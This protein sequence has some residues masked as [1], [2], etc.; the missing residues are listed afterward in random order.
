MLE[1]AGYITGGV[2][3]LTRLV[4]ESTAFQRRV[5]AADQFEAERHIRRWEYREENPAHLH[6]ARPFA[7]I[8]PGDYF[9]MEPFAGGQVNWLTGKGSLVLLLTDKDTYGLESR[10]ESGDAFAGWID[11]VL[12]DI[13]DHPD[14][15]S[16]LLNMRIPAMVQP[17]AHSPTKDER[18]EGAYWW[19]S[20]LVEFG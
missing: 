14:R 13:R 10:S 8:W 5:K 18:S 1:A 16:R 9:T 20:F 7:A 19:A 6:A 17:P 11:A 15:E 12:G 3:G 4:S 2:F